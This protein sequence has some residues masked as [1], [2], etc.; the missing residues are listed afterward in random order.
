MKKGSVVSGHFF[1]FRYLIKPQL[2]VKM[3]CVAPKSVAK[4]AVKRNKL[5][6]R[7]Y[8]VLRKYPIK[9]GQGIFFYK[10]E[11]V[12]ADFKEINEDIGFLLKKTHF[13]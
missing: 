8:S 9:G 13:I 1:M 11:G 2:G 3:A 6:R 12:N 10:K 5:R 4:N 7:A